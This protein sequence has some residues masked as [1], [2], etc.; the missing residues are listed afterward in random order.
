MDKPYQPNERISEAQQI[1][2]FVVDKILTTIWLV[3]KCFFWLGIAYITYLAVKELAGQTTIASFFLSYF[4]GND[5]RSQNNYSYIWILLAVLFGIWAKFE[6]WLRY[7]K[8][9][10]MSARI[11]YLESKF[12]STRTSSGLM[13]TGETPLEERLP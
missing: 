6:R 12:D 10:S 5:A 11:S 3:I 13:S 8:V 9:A 4:V 2:L 7:R 1:R